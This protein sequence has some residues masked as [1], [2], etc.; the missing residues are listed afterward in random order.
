M[1]V[2]PAEASD[3][4]VAWGFDDGDIED[5]AANFM[6]ALL[7]LVLGEIDKSLVRNGFDEAVTEK[8]EGDAEG[9]NLFAVGNMLLNFGAGEGAAGADGAVVNQGAAFDDFRAVVNGNF[10]VLKVAVEVTMTYAQFGHLAGAAGDGALV[11]LPAGLRVVEGA[12]AVGGSFCFVELGLIGDV[13]GGVD[14]AIAL[15]IE[16]G[17]SFGERRRERENSKRH[18]GE[19]SE[20]GFHGHLRKAGCGNVLNWRIKAK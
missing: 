20:K 8:I 4:G 7:A 3:S 14:K 5:L 15:V 18:K 11:A 19:E 17:G 1:L 6:T 2:F 9:P 10:R 13:S 12:E 16:A